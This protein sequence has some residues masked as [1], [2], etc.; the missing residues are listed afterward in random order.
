MSPAH[1]WKDRGT[2]LPGDLYGSLLSL[3]PYGAI[4]NHGALEDLLIPSLPEM[5]RFSLSPPWAGP[6][7][8]VLCCGV[9]RKMVPSGP[10]DV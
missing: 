2:V 10:E 9:T 7:G 1:S 8:S 4:L 6:V 5:E 3:C